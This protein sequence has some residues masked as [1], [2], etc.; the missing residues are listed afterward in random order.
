MDLLTEHT[1]LT[2][3]QALDGM[4]VEPEHLYVI[5]PGAYLSVSS[6]ALRLSPPEMRDG[7]PHGARFPFDALLHSMAGEYGRRDACVVLSGT[8]DDGSAGLRAIKE[9]GGL[10]VAQDPD[11]AGHDGMP[12]SA[13]ATGLVDAVLPVA[14]IPEALAADWASHEQPPILRS[15]GNAPPAAP[16]SPVRDAEPAQPDPLS[17][18]IELLHARTKH[19]FAPY[20][21]GTLERRVGRRMGMAIPGSGDVGRYLGLL[22]SDAGEL[23]LLA[24]DLL[25]RLTSFFRDPA[26]FNALARTIIPGLLRDRVPGEP[27]RIWV[28]GCSTGEEAY[29]LVILF[30][31]ALANAH[32]GEGPDIKLQVFASDIDP[33]AAAMAREGLYPATIATDVSAR[34]L[35]RFFTREDGH[36]Y[37]VNPDIRASVVFTVQDLLT[38]PPFSRLDLVSCRN[39]VIDLGPD[40]QARAMTLFHFALKEG[41]SCCCAPPKPPAKGMAGSS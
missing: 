13:I 37:R 31:E 17:S 30:R 20:K 6:G 40:A 24:K 12:R 3:V 41:A 25:I 29:S 19:D 22:R 10:V 16:S 8:G 18:I 38:D 34:R 9:G 7:A 15:E 27:L 35:A 39:L 33:D 36:G 23:D 32:D 26:V 5:P 21:R 14:S 1:A 11:E 4:P 28:A 2:V